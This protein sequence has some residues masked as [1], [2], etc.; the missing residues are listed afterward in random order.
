MRTSTERNRRVAAAELALAVAADELPAYSCPKSPRRFTQPQLLACLVLR[1]YAKQTYRGV[2]DLLGA[3][4]DLRRVLGLTRVPDYS[5]LQRFADR[6]VTP[7][8]LDRVLGRL[9]ERV[10]P[11]I[12]EVAMDSTGMEPSNASAYYTARRGTRHK[13][14]VKLSLVIVCG[15]LLPLALVV[16]RGPRHDTCEAEEVM[17]RASGKGRPERLY[18]DKGYDAER[19]H[20]FCFEVWR[21]RSYI[22][23]VVR[24]RDGKVGGRYRSRM[25]RKPKGYGK[26][27]HAE[28]FMSGLKRT[29]GSALTSR[30]DNTLDAEAALRVLAYSV[31]R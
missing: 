20:R 13:G 29:T 11:V 31:R 30:K 12:E 1:A 14:Y 10:G 23:P 2:A 27:W 9:V 26:R 24:R 18:A 25:R 4:D 16:S 8:V 21:V 3:S 7:A 22:P 5:T 6:V 15:C 19:V 17:R 28:S